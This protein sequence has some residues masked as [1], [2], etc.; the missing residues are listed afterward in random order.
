MTQEAKKAKTF[1]VTK[2]VWSVVLQS[3][4]M[5]DLERAFSMVTKLLESA[6]C[7]SDPQKARAC[8]T[9]GLEELR[10]K[11]GVPASNGRK[12]DGEHRPTLPSYHNLEENARTFLQITRWITNECY[13]SLC[14]GPKSHIQSNED[15]V[16]K[17][18]KC[19]GWCVCMWLYMWFFFFPVGVL[20][21]IPVPAAKCYTFHWDKDNFGKSKHPFETEFN[22]KKIDCIISVYC[23]VAWIL[24]VR[25]CTEVCR[26][27][28][29]TLSVVFHRALGALTAPS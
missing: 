29:N 21:T 15:T 1:G 25:P 11:L 10:E 28:V 7:V 14:V 26:K 27:G 22:Q 4:S 3:V 5:E 2:T 16:I 13:C 9:Q 17:M 24:D 23:T 12:S 19:D 20:E 8:L 18:L 6:A